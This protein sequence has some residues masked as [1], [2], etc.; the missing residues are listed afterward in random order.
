MEDRAHELLFL[1][2]YCSR[3]DGLRA[4]DVDLLIKGY[5][6]TELTFDGDMLVLG[7]FLMDRLTF[8]HLSSVM[9]C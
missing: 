2:D 5:L 8:W 7:L 6:R 3:T 1:W 9:L 4:L